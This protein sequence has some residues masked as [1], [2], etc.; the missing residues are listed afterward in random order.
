[1]YM[2]PRL[3]KMNVQRQADLG[4]QHP[5]PVR[6]VLCPPSS[7]RSLAFS[8]CSNLAIEHAGLWSYVHAW[9]MK[10]AN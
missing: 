7:E 4:H 6:L 2:K 9:W 8:S 10:P 5:E 3:N 1:M